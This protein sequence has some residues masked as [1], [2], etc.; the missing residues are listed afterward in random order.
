MATAKQKN[1]EHASWKPAKYTDAD[2]H[3]MQALAKGSASADQQKRA[4]RWIIE[5]AA[6][7]YDMH[8]RP[9]PEGARDTDFALGRCFVG[10]QVVKLMKLKVGL[11]RREE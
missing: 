8:Y 2:V 1:E 11:L 4:L 5:D 10:Q 7:T 3:A 6:G 9:G